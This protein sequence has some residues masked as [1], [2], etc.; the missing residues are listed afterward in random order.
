VVGTTEAIVYGLMMEE[1]EYGGRDGTVVRL[2]EK[3]G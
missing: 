3:D 1:Y 2:E